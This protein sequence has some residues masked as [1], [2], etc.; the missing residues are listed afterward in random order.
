MKP[1]EAYS[2][3]ILNK[4]SSEEIVTV[5]NDWLVDGIY[6]KNFGEF[7]FI[8]NPIMSDV[9]PIFKQTMAEL[10]VKEPT[11]I[12]AA[13][14]IIRMK[15]KQVVEKSIPPE[16]GASFLYWNV[17]HELMQELPDKKYV[18]DNLDLQNIFCWLREIWDC[19]DGSMI[20]YYTNLPREKAEIKF[21]EHLI[22]EAENWLK[23]QHNNALY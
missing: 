17:H 22:E 3:F 14:I 2:L 21:N 18:G 9:A 1:I 5:A 11:R 8:S 10:G 4:I 16:E 15:L 23:N 20:L 12:E 19:R 7:A 6:S 13:K